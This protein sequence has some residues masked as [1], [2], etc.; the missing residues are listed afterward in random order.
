[1]GSK[2]KKLIDKMLFLA[3]TNTSNPTEENKI[4]VTKL[5]NRLDELSHQ[6]FDI[7]VTE[8]QEIIDDFA[9]VQIFLGESKSFRG[10][11]MPTSLLPRKKE[12]IEAALAIAMKHAEDEDRKFALRLNYVQLMDGYIEDKKADELNYSILKNIIKYSQE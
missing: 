6:D 10:P 8:A 12:K 1:M 7:T 11:Y 2:T 4:R 3:N 5:F 9:R